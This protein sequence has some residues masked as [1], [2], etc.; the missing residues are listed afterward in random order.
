MGNTPVLEIGDEGPSPS[1]AAR[2]IQ[3]RN[4]DWGLRIEK[5]KLFLNPQSEIRIPQSAQAVLT[6]CPHSN[7]FQERGTMSSVAESCTMPKPYSKPEE[8][9]SLV[10]GFES[11]TLPRE[12]WTHRAHLTVALWYLLHHDTEEATTLIREGIKRFNEAKGI[13]TTKQSGYHETITLFYIH[14]VSKHL[15]ESCADL[16]IVSL[17]NKLIERYGERSLPLEYYSK[18]RLMSWEARANW[19]EPDLKPLG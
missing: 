6:R 10:N 11:C 8:I 5:Q 9:E 3:L 4:A 18:E 14:I 7:L 2:T 17:M 13:V 19:I 15:R 12:E 1:P 16:S